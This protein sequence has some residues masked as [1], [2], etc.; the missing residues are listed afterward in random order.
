MTTNWTKEELL[1][2]ILIW[3]A[4]ADFIVDEAET[5]QI[6]SKVEESVFKKVKREFADDNDMQRLQKVNAALE[7]L[8]Y[9]S[10]GKSEIFEEMKE[11]FLS[12]GNYNTLEKNLELGFKK[13]FS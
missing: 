3:S 8:N 9:S 6:L 12:D 11:L 5:D 13:I 4:N 10:E 1:A 2:Y 7:R